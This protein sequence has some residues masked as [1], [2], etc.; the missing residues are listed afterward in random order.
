[1]FFKGP[2]AARGLVNGRGPPLAVGGMSEAK[3]S[4]KNTFLPQGIAMSEAKPTQGG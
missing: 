1:M 2:V 4:L 3:A